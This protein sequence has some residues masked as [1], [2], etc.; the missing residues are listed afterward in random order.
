MESGTESYCRN[1]AATGI[2]TLIAWQRP[3]TDI[4]GESSPK[5][6]HELEIPHVGV[7]LRYRRV[8]V[9]HQ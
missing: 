9:E 6:D 2:P 3:P 1:Q 7:G 8:V 4:P 5:G